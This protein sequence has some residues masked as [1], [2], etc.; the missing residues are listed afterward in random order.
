M[1][2]SS[3]PEYI[4]ERKKKAPKAKKLVQD[5]EFYRF[6]ATKDVIGFD[7]PQIIEDDWIKEEDSGTTTS[8]I[9][10]TEEMQ[11]INSLSSPYEFNKHVVRG[12]ERFH[13]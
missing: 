9:C 13:Y 10:L 7:I 6:L 4:S 8:E 1:I 3:T 12:R 11:Y 2:M 5:A